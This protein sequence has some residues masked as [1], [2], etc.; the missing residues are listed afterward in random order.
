MP[1]I[2]DV[3][4]DVASAALGE[5]A[6][7]KLLINKLVNRGRSR[8]HP[9]STF[10]NY[11]SWRGLTDKTYFARLLPEK[12]YPPAEA[13]GTRKPPLA[14]VVKLF[15]A[16]P[17]AQRI[18]PKSTMLFPAFAQY[19]TDGFLRTQLTNDK[20]FGA[21]KLHATEPG[22]CIDRVIKEDR[23]R[24]TS[25]HDI[26]MSPLYGRNF[27]QTDALRLK[28]SKAGRRGRLKTQL[29]NGEEWPEFMFDAAG[30]VKKEFDALD[31]PLGID[32]APPAV[33]ATLFAVGGDRVNAAPAV[34]MMNALWLREHNRLAAVIEGGNPGWDDDRVFETARNV[35]IWMFIKIVVEEY[36]NH[37]NTA[38]FKFIA[39]PEVAWEADWN[40][41]NWMTIEFSL[42]Y[43]WHPLVPETLDWM[44]AQMSGKDT[45]L[46][47]KLLTDTGLANAFVAFAANP[48]TCLGLGN[49]ATF[50]VKAEEKAVD[51]AR[52]NNIASFNDY[53]EAMGKDRVESFE[54]L[55]GKTKDEKEKKRR[56][57]LAAELK[58][59][60]GH[61]DNL[62]F[63][64]G[65]FAQPP[66]R[67]G[68]LPDM[69]LAMVAMDAFSQALTNPLLSEHILGDEK[70]KRIAFTD[71]GIV[72]V[73]K[74]R[75]LA[76]ILDRNTANLNGRFAGF[77]RP[78]WKRD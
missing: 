36:I 10:N 67:N 11:I 76:D 29:I 56:K 13:L 43:R 33:L 75:R 65:L 61:I 73:E 18:C 57:A 39:D 24:T 62:E 44:G 69:V 74:T 4:L 34:S 58:R 30:A 48:A 47:N 60:Y 42:L 2:Q 63:Y 32:K 21:D 55:V 64:V 72:A 15:A 5:K 19:L 26:D 16:A 68:P 70:N 17:N 71:V 1:G 8:P 9:W 52:Q 50:L 53:C 37:I 78:G 3:L 22:D 54:E 41:P 35:V 23:K 12:P 6:L 27:D 77:T 46:N 38:D 66:D 31:R 45:L 20:K 59:L 25:T 51:Q 40:R 7:N 49:S 14:D 28:S